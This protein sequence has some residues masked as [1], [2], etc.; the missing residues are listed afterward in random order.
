MRARYRDEREEKREKKKWSPF[1]CHLSTPNFFNPP[2]V[3]P[4]AAPP[5]VTP[6]AV[7]V[8]LATHTHH[9]SRLTVIQHPGWTVGEPGH[10]ATDT[11]GT[12]GEGA[13]RCLGGKE[14]RKRARGRRARWRCRKPRREGSGH[15]R[16]GRH[17]KEETRA[18]GVKS[19]NRKM[20]NKKKEKRRG[21][22]SKRREYKIEEKKVTEKRVMEKSERRQLRLKR[23]KNERKKG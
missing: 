17:G 10:Q 20:L 7:V 6:L 12:G 19:Y 5:L 23:E 14:S 13:E 11:E 8:L 18:D 21:W 3:I 9:T 2:P 15:I 22:E 1:F 16:P 4:F